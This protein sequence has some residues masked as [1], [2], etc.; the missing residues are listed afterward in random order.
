MGIFWKR[1]RHRVL[2]DRQERLAARVAANLI[3]RQTKI[4]NYLNRKTQ[5]WNKSSKVIALILFCLAFGG[6][7][8]YLLIK[9][10]H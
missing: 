3:R 8:L 10:C 6:V 9:A 1:D 7:S 2:T 5:Y 4:A